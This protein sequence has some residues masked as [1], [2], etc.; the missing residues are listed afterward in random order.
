MIKEGTIRI[1]V[2][3][4]QPYEKTKRSWKKS[5]QEFPEIKEVV[6][7]YKSQ[8]NFK[9]LVD[10]KDPQ[11][12]KGQLSPEGLVQGAR[13]NVLPNNQ[14]L[15]KAF[16]LFAKNLTV[17]D[18]SSHDH[19]D[20]LFQN[21]GGTW[22][23]CY[24]L[25]K[26]KKNQKKKYKKVEKFARIYSKLRRKVSLALNN[27]KDH[28]AVPMETMLKTRMR[29]G[30]EI[31]YKAH[32]HKGLTTL[33]K[34]DVQIK[35]EEVRFKY[36]AKD[37]V[38]QLIEKKFSPIYVKRLKEILK[39]KKREEFIFSQNERLLTEKDFKKAFRQYCGQ[40]FYPHIIRS[41]YA[42]SK[43]KEFLMKKNPSKEEAKQFLLG[44]AG[45]LGHKRFVK[46]EQ[47][48]KEHYAVTM[49]NYIQ[50]QLV[51]RLKKII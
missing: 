20:V 9:I 7:L 34:K 17:H 10:K 37:G 15:D 13:L 22:N 40:E 6:K 3:G 14:V 5:K 33:K 4:L 48:W 45:E 50:P 30:N 25:E 32:R 29:I 18:E 44:I 19:W 23:Y 49:N 42:T 24:T 2:K 39:K 16:S 38:P 28:L 35:G 31:Y 27:K 41:H 26:K 8:K 11:F 46:K 1:K 36:I 47:Q 43:V 51:K 21:K 12:L